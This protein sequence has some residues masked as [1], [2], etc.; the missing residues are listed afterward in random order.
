MKRYGSVINVAAFIHTNQ[1]F[2]GTKHISMC[3]VLH[4]NLARQ[5]Y[6]TVKQPLSFFRFCVFSVCG[7]NG[8]R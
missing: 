1:L 2:A 5:C 4:N 7:W 3:K 6:Y 8:N